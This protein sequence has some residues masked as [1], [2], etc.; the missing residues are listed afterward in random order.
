MSYKE[1]ISPSGKF[2]AI[3]SPITNGET[4]EY[5]TYASWPVNTEVVHTIEKYE[6]VQIFRIEESGD[7]LIYQYKRNRGRQPY[8][9]FLRNAAA[10]GEL[11]FGGRHYLLRLILNC[12]TGKCY[13]EPEP[14]ELD[15]GRFI[16]LGIDKI[17]ANG[18]YI[19]VD[20]CIWACPYEKIIYDI[21]DLSGRG[22]VEIDVDEYFHVLCDEE[23]KYSFE[24]N[25]KNNLD[26]YEINK[27]E[28]EEKYYGTIIINPTPL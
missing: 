8:T 27:D 22:A 9:G 15:G 16:W 14:N 25:D 12:E 10:G 23:D 26:I 21:S 13:D 7:S 3:I 28:M 19:L 4:R 2:K 5:I 1:I 11:W 20:G 18:N 6:C 24:F 17:S